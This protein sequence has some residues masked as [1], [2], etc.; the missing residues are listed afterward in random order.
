MKKTIEEYYEFH[1]NSPSDINEHFETLKRYSSECETIVEM[2]VREIKSTWSFIAGKPKKVISIDFQHPDFFGGDISE[3][4]RICSDLQIDYEFKLENTLECDIEVC[5]LLF[6]D[7]WHDFLQLKCELFRHSSKVRKY[8]IL[9]DTY[10][11]GFNNEPLYSD[12][13]NTRPETN[14][15]KGLLAAVDE[16]I[17]SNKEWFIFERFAN[18]NGLTV[19][20]RKL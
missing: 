10:S 7:T 5:D 12:Y 2:G 6:I 13:Q 16:F 3:V 17:H 18:N 20:K 14:L 11:Y 15:P 8:I 4:Y 19:L 9:H 1:K